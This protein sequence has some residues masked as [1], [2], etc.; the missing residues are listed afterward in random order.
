MKI[1]LFYFALISVLLLLITSCQPANSGSANGGN[2]GGAGKEIKLA[3][4]TNNASD[5]WTIARKGVEKAD[6]E[7]ADVT[8]DFKLPGS[9]AADEQKRIIDDLISKGINGIAISP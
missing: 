6:G 3:F 9:G 8:V 4:V 5:Y 2:S 7:L 1:K